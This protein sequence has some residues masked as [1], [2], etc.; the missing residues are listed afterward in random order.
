MLYDCLRYCIKCEYQKITNFLGNISNKI[1]KFISK[2]QIEFCDQ[3][4]YNY[5]I[6]KQ[7]RFKTPMLQSVCVITVVRILLLK[8]LLLLHDQMIMHIY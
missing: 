7:I 1:P 4:N 6:N 3:S 5:N 8:K 2:K